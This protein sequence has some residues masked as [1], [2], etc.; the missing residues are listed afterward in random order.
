MTPAQQHTLWLQFHVFQAKLEKK[1]TPV[2]K[3]TI[4]AQITVFN[5]HAKVVGYD[6]A[7][8]RIYDYFDPAPIMNV[9]NDIH[10]EAAGKWGSFIYKQ[11]VNVKL[12]TGD[13]LHTVH[14]GNQYKQMHAAIQL[15]IKPTAIKRVGS[16]GV[17][18]DIAKQIIAELRLSLLNNVHGITDS[19]KE[20]ILHW[21]QVGQEKGWSYDE[22]AKMIQDKV[23][24]AYRSQRIVRTES[25]KASN[26]GG[27]A[28]AKRTGLL[29]DKVWINAKD[30]RVRGNPAAPES[31]FDHWDI[32]GHIL[33]ID[34]PFLLGS[35]T[36]GNA[37]DSLM[38]PGDPKGNPAD[39]INCRCTLGYIPRRDENG[40]PIRVARPVFN[41]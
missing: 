23:G 2:M 29:M 27:I 12:R 26:M 5:A 19:I 7:A 34:Q 30:N 32:G 11:Y 4:G 16:F 40:L 35:R 20:D 17:S 1:Y 15:G 31:Q 9:V 18:D 37:S 21:I 14:A 24:S 39:I 38:F 3:R 10:F 41:N 33:P 6:K 25:V 36:T 8:S 22:T 13:I 28:G